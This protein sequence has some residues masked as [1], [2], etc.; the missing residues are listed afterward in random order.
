[1]I[2][3]TDADTS[4]F[5]IDDLPPFLKER[6]AVYLGA[7]Y[8]IMVNVNN[9]KHY[10]RPATKD[11]VYHLTTTPHPNVLSMSVLAPALD[12]GEEAAIE[13]LD[14][15][16]PKPDGTLGFVVQGEGQFVFS[17]TACNDDCY[18]CG[19][20]PESFRCDS[21]LCVSAYPG[22]DFGVRSTDSALCYKTTKDGSTA[23]VAASALPLISAG[24]E[25]SDIVRERR[26]F[27]DKTPRVGERLPIFIWVDGKKRYLSHPTGE[28]QPI[29]YTLTETPMIEGAAIVPKEMATWRDMSLTPDSFEHF[30][31]DR[32]QSIAL[33]RNAEKGEAVLPKLKRQHASPITDIPET[34]TKETP[35]TPIWKRW[36]FWVI[37]AIAFLLLIFFVFKMFK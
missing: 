23:S 25:S 24:Q 31:V 33:W 12:R 10:L 1:M 37:V 28:E 8:P 6:Q 19:S 35:P 17:P 11:H 4:T 34:T 9:E 5:Y 26:F 32:M 14:M 15:P 21:A 22:F 18:K 29:Q 7:S 30:P 2:L 3:S 36:W 27:V 13:E 20:C 16:V